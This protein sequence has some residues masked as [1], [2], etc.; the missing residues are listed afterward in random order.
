MEWN[1][2]QRKARSR[3]TARATPVRVFAWT[4][5]SRRPVPSTCEQSAQEWHLLNRKQQQDLLSSSSSSRTVR[6]GSCLLTEH[7]SRLLRP[8]A[9]ENWSRGRNCSG[10]ADA[11]WVDG[12]LRFFFF[13]LWHPGSSLSDHYQ[14]AYINKRKYSFLALMCPGQWLRPLETWC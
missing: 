12:N 5:R 6:Y 13:L 9:W 11:V 7:R 8:I 14:K 3:L 2:A 1:S 10:T 4:A